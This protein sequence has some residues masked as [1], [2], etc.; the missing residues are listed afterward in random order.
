MKTLE[1]GKRPFPVMDKKEFE[2]AAKNNRREDTKKKVE[3]AKIDD[4]NIYRKKPIENKAK[5]K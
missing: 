3:R 5:K 1:F 2:K 4:S